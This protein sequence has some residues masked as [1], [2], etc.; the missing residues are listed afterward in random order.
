M[1]TTSTVFGKFTIV[2]AAFVGLLF[3][4]SGAR[5]QSSSANELAIKPTT[6]D[7]DQAESAK[8]AYRHAHP[9]NTAAGQ[10]LRARQTALRKQSKDSTPADD[11]GIV[12]YE[13]DLSNQGGEVV[14]TTVFHAIYMR[15]GG[16]CPIATCWGD[17]ERFLRDLGD[18]NFIHL[19]DQYV[20]LHSS[21]RYTVG[22][23]AKVDYT[24]PLVPLIDT[25]IQAVVHAVAMASGDTGYGH[26]YHVFLPP[27]QDE[28]FDSTFTQ[29]YSPNSPAVFFYCAYHSSVDFTD[30]GHVVYSVEP[31]QNVPG[32]QVEPGTPNGSLVDSTDNVLNHETFEA[33]S[34]PDGTA[35]FNTTSLPLFGSENGDECEFITFVGQNAYF[36]PPTFKINGHFYAVQSIYSNDVHAC[37]TAP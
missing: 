31:F 19:A 37:G 1:K 32:C 20:G 29:C 24:P 36:N 16:K 23:H 15:P 8:T 27:G 25:D 18:S 3:A 11:G 33:I 14:K 22:F 17:P 4:T 9:A 26:M 12:T 7:H 21:N 10:E 35:W 2:V 5:A 13:G 6:F 30:I 28:C 34:D